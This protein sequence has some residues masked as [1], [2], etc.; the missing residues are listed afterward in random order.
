MKKRFLISIF[1]LAVCLLFAGCGTD[2]AEQTTPPPTQAIF[3]STPSPTTA[4]TEPYFESMVWIPTNGG[5]KY[6]TDA[7]CSNMIDPEKV[8]QA[9]AESA[10]FTPCQNCY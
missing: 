6:H 7:D 1:A 3:S 8:S 4:P 2:A 9:E 5:T 10:G